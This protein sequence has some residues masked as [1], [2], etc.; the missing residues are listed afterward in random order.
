MRPSD[1]GL[2]FYLGGLDVAA[3]LVVVWALRDTFD[4]R[5]GIDGGKPLAVP[6]PLAMLIL[7]L[8]LAIPMTI[9]VL[10]IRRFLARH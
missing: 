7:W 3:L 8:A 6:K 5:I 9:G 4:N 2:W 1:Q 10:L